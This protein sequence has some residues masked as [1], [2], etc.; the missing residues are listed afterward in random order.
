MGKKFIT[1]MGGARSGKSRLAADLAKRYGRNVLFVA[2]AQPSD[3]EMSERIRVH[4]SERPV[5]W[6]TSETPVD[7]GRAIAQNGRDFDTV[8]IDCITLLVSNLM[9]RPNVREQQLWTAA[10]SEV[11]AIAEAYRA[12]SATFI[13]VTNEVG[14][15]IVPAYP[16]GRVYRDVL[17]RTNR[18]LAQISDEAVMLIAGFPVDIKNARTD[19]SW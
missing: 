12:L 8:I 1:I 10:E 14:L 13:V 7:V 4:R 6:Q 15:G 16:A 9:R 19:L 17:G 2:T 11:E 3:R 18:M 5:E